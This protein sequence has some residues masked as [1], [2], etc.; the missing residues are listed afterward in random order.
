MLP[1]G[2]SYCPEEEVDSSMTEISVLL[3][4]WMEAGGETPRRARR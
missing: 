1:S 2:K 3:K 4:A